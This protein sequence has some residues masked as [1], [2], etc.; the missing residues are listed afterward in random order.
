LANINKTVKKYRTRLSG[1]LA[2]L[3]I[4]FADP[5]SSTLVLGLPIIVMG[6]A[7]RIWSSGHIH[8]NEVLTV[9][10]PYSLTRNP[11]YLGS[12]I[13]AAG[14]VVAMDVLWMSLVFLL[15]FVV[16]YW[17]T[18]R[19]E[20]DKMK[21]KFPT[22]WEEYQRRIPRFFPLFHPK[23]YIPDEFSWSQVM[24]NR[25]MWNAAAVLAVYAILWCKLLWPGIR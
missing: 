11:L 22:Q 20:E 7:I 3:F 5:T 24:K 25:E 4:I 9:T 16:V 15:F 19:W 12:F 18:I 8:K 13:L 23:C 14:F 21:R 2:V 6:E 1:V 10:G 17:A